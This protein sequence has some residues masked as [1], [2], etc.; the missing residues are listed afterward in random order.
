ML[1]FMTLFVPDDEES[2]STPFYGCVA[3]YDTLY[4]P[5]HGFWTLENPRVVV[6]AG[7]HISCTLYN[8]ISDSPMQNPQ[9]SS[10]NDIH[11]RWQ[12]I[13]MIGPQKW[14]NKWRKT[15]IVVHHRTIIR[16]ISLSL[17]ITLPSYICNISWPC[18]YQITK[19]P[20]PHPSTVG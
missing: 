18:L 20:C 16:V 5:L 15:I 2:S 11:P 3:H 13:H 6:T 17:I 8:L 19:N 14:I 4:K 1:Y 10:L 9:I 12:L 7:V